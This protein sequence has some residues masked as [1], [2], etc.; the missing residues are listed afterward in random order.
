MRTILI[1]TGCVAVFA[2]LCLAETFNGKLI[3]A[4][5]A[6]QQQASSSCTPT[7]ST[8][9]YAIDVSGKIY[10]LDDS[11]NAK[12][13]DAMKNQANRESNPDS[14]KKTAVTARVNG[15]LEGEIIKVETIEVR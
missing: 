4:S 10:K 2:G 12:A 13:A 11:G 6:T 3:D 5:C 14:T 1:A 7:A 8:T 15:T 9:M